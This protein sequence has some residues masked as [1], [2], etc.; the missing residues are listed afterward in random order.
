M[1]EPMRDIAIRE[2]VI[3]GGGLAGW[4]SAARLCQAMRGRAVRVRVVHAAPAGAEA[5]PLDVLCASTLPSLAV[6][7]AELGIEERD[8]MRA[9]NATFKLATEYRGFAEPG[10]S[11]MWPFGEIGARL[12]AVG[13]HQ[14]MNRLMR[15][16][17]KLDIDE[18]SI[19]AI[20]ARLGRFAHPSQDERTVLSTYE[21][22]YHLDVHAYTRMLR[23]FA[24][25]HGAQA[26]DADLAG[27]TCSADG[28][29][30]IALQPGDG[31]QIEGD[32]FIDCTGVR[33]ALLGQALRVPFDDWRPWLPCDRVAVMRAKSAEPAAPF[34]RIA[35]Q[36]QGWL[37]QVP[38]NGA[39][40]HA[41]A[42]T[43]AGLDSDVAMTK[44]GSP[45]MN[46]GSP[47][48]LTFANGRHR[49]FW[50]G[51]CVA[52]GA[53][54]GFLEPLAATG[55]RLIDDGI[56]RLIALFPDRDD[57]ALMAREYNR[58]LDAAYV[59]ARDFVLLHYLVSRRSGEALWSARSVPL[60]DSLAQRIELF[61]YRGRVIFHEDEIFEEPDWACTFI[62]QGERPRHFSV[63]AGQMNDDEALRQVAKIARVMQSAAQ[64]LPPHQAYLERYL[65]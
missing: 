32:L 60:P 23:A 11:Y 35:A 62:G 52:I 26:V 40:D 61:R 43:S 9:S 46:I 1:S 39:V 19:P 49:E 16:G 4:Y 57:T 2:V 20:A 38:L 51:N 42:F 59:S 3:V 44:L 47:R 37:A 36:A 24:Q 45:G 64:K 28:Q 58:V 30:V 6:A 13:F 27:V 48:L 56:A 53:A 8:F 29:R 5:D 54:A 55:L 65:A 41:L 14:F 22:G 31:A 25:H 18:F 33:S 12:E 21:Y 15:A 63:L 50:H 17:R 34:T 7:H 10:H